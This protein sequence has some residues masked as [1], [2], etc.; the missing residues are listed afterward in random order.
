MCIIRP[1]KYVVFLL[2][3]IENQQNDKNSK[4]R[5]ASLEESRKRQKGNTMQKKLFVSDF[6]GTITAKDFFLIYMDK[7][8]GQKGRQ[9][10]EEYRAEGNPSYQFLNWV[11]D[12][13]ALT[14]QE[15]QELLKEIEWDE[16]FEDFLKEIPKLGFD[17]LILSAGVHFY[18]RDALALKGIS[19]QRIIANDGGFVDG[20]IVLTHDKNSVIFSELY[21]VDKGKAMEELR[22]E[23]DVIYFAGDSIPDV[24]AAMQADKVFAKGAL[25]GYFQKEPRSEKQKQDRERQKEV[26]SFAK[27]SQIREMLRV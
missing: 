2:C 10:L 8:I 24:S 16:S 18:I 20:K 7:F 6:D 13:R 9:F 3:R 23:Y 25:L 26:Y 15:Y 11:F 14:E 27:Y 12:M 19:P 17:H 21:G 4:K 1:K 5:Y 22:K